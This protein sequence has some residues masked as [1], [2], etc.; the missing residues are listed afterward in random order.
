MLDSAVPLIKSLALQVDFLRINGKTNHHNKLNRPNCECEQYKF[1]YVIAMFWCWNKL[2]WLRSQHRHTYHLI[3]LK[4][5]ILVQKLKTIT[6]IKT[7]FECVFGR[8]IKWKEWPRICYACTHRTKSLPHSIKVLM[9]R[10]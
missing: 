2:N 10:Q 1:R 6:S 9:W 5:T 3:E 4:R 7:T 8:R